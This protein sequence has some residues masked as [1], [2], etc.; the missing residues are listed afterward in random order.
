LED[1]FEG[2][3]TRRI[4]THIPHTHLTLNSF[5]VTYSIHV[6]EDLGQR[7]SLQHEYG[8]KSDRI[9]LFAVEHAE[10]VGS[11]IYPALET[12]VVIDQNTG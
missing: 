7:D 10:R 4:E 6:A 12:P 5:D 2:E 1:W 9:R 3:I 11:S 8:I